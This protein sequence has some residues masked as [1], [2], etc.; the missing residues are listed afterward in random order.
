MRAWAREPV[1]VTSY[2][3]PSYRSKCFTSD[4]KDEMKLEEELGQKYIKEKE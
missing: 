3:V 2:F 4:L 1:P